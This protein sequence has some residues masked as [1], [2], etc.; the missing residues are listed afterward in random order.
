MGAVAADRLILQGIERAVNARRLVPRYAEFFPNVAYASFTGPIPLEKWIECLSS[1]RVVFA[2]S[3]NPP[4]LVYVESE[5]YPVAERA[6]ALADPLA[7]LRVISESVVSMP[8]EVGL[9]P[10]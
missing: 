3:N 10:L 2:A 5:S 4:S 1:Q 9:Q 8:A 6:F 7:L